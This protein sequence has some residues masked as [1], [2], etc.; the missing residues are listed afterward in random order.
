MV[1]EEEEEEEVVVVAALLPGKSFF[2]SN[3]HYRPLR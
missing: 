1:V 3:L 2:C